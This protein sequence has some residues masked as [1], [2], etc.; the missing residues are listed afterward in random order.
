MFHFDLWRSQ[1]PNPR[2]RGAAA[3]KLIRY[4]RPEALQRV[5]ELLKDPAPQ[6]A[7]DA[8][9]A[10]ERKGDPAAIGALIEVL[11]APA[12][13]VREQAAI[14]LRQIDPEW[15]KSGVARAMLPSMVA[16]LVTSDSAS[17][18]NHQWPLLF[19]DGQALEPL[20][21][22]LRKGP[23]EARRRALSVM[24]DFADWTRRSTNRG[25]RDETAVHAVVPLLIEAL[26][27]L[28][29]DDIRNNVLRLLDWL[30]SEWPE[31]A[32]AHELAPRLL[33]DLESGVLA[34]QS[35]A[36]SALQRIREPRCMDV[37][38]KLLAH[39]VLGEAAMEA[40]RRQDYGWMRASGA[41]AAVP[42]LMQAFESGNTAARQSAARK[43]KLIPEASLGPLLEA[44][45]ARYSTIP[46][47]AALRTLQFEPVGDADR[48]LFALISGYASAMAGREGFI[49][50]TIVDALADFDSLR[51]RIGNAVVV[52]LRGRSLKTLAGGDVAR[53]HCMRETAV[54]VLSQALE[55]GVS[56]RL[57]IIRMMAAAGGARAV[58]P[59]LRYLFSCANGP[60]R[61]KL[62]AVLLELAGRS[63]LTEELVR[64]AARCC[65]HDVTFSRFQADGN[66][67]PALEALGE[68]RT[69]R[70]PL[71]DNLLRLAADKSDVDIRVTMCSDFPDALGVH[72]DYSELRRRATMELARRGNPP[73]RPE[74]Y[75]KEEERTLPPVKPHDAEEGIPAGP[76]AAPETLAPSLVSDRVEARAAAVA[77]LGT[78]GDPVAVP[79]LVAALEDPFEWVRSEALSALDRLDPAWRSSEP[80]RHL[81]EAASASLNDPDRT[82]RGAAA[83]LLQTLGWSPGTVDERVRMALALE[84]WHALEHIGQ[85]AIA[86]I[87]NLL[88][89]WEGQ[90]LKAAL[91]VLHKADRDWAAQPGARAVLPVLMAALEDNNPGLGLRR[92]AA[93]LL[94]RMREATALEA[95][96]RLLADEDKETRLA[97]GA[98]LHEIGAPG[99]MALLVALK[100][101]DNRARSAAQAALQRDPDPAMAEAFEEALADD[102]LSVQRAAARGLQKLGR[103]AKP[104]H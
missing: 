94:G 71:T 78:G 84:D 103:P 86:P 62:V 33:A 63:I 69:D 52:F 85:P 92:E 77:L 104:N 10:L 65:S 2:T 36:V 54:A 98:A 18:T 53:L 37:L 27:N 32:A 73:Y 4:T 17:W 99:A 43:L 56:D 9:R 100:S 11:S 68:L 29:E 20:A 35:A 1:S 12:K 40:L 101:Q 6:V 16:D 50:E 80:A 75:L 90:A 44:F 24:N 23:P 51:K 76:S 49:V 34:A 74:A 96:A 5:I 15:H 89:S 61:E 93:V 19:M 97:A 39:P 8:A 42:A 22:V 31:S 59:L 25:W 45:R 81:L 87:L 83:S 60:L 21:D 72:L 28:E 38:F 64:S 67:N 55:D 82:R 46:G 66:I 13:Q 91:R 7:V 30:D 48:A 26:P 95:L 47:L 58:D 57:S 102:N 14:T 88:A 3:F 79:L 41:A 70:S